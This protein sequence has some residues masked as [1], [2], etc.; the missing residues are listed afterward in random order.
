MATS[1]IDLDA[2][3]EVAGKLHGGYL[4][5]TM[6][7][8]A[9]DDTHPHPLAASTHF[10]SSPE[11]GAAVV[12]VERLRTGRTIATS[13]IRL[14]QDGR[15]RVE[16]LLTSGRLDPDSE[17]RWS[18]GRPPELPPVEDCPRAPAE[19]TL[20]IRV[21]ILDHIEARMDISTTQWA[22]GLPG[23]GAGVVRG[24]MRRADGVDTTPTDLLV[25]TDALPPVTFDLGIF[26]WVPTLELTV[27]IRALPAAG[28]VQVVQRAQL[29]QGGW[30]DEECEIWDSAGRLVAQ[31][32]QLAAYRE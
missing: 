30:L 17:P 6:T 22:L 24:W 5:A 18:G 32:R 27:L 8:C 20:G 9:L 10:L 7:R 19:S 14:L 2:S 23:A 29:L 4:L 16:V 26:G 21:G 12:E 28:W 31:A 11:P 1:E 15:A 25:F 3:W 13:R